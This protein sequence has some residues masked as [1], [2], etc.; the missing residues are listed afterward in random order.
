[1]CLAILGRNN[2]SSKEHRNPAIGT[3]FAAQSQ[4]ITAGED[5]ERG[6]TMRHSNLS[7]SCSASPFDV[8]F[9]LLKLELLGLVSQGE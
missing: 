5:M 4:E 2:F 3:M 8:L 1:M 7:C 6:L 9:L